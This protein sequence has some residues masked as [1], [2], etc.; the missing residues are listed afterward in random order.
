MVH[1]C[2]LEMI[3]VKPYDQLRDLIVSFIV[4]VF[5]VVLKR[6]DSILSM[7]NVLCLVFYITSTNRT[8]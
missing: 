6:Y 5:V 2:N 8:F 4:T 1:V 7:K 3:L